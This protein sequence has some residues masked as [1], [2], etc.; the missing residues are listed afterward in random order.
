MK[1]GVDTY[2]E[3]LAVCFLAQ[4][5]F[6]TKALQAGKP[7]GK[8]EFAMEHIIK[9]GDVVKSMCFLYFLKLLK[10]A[11]RNPFHHFY[12]TQKIASRRVEQRLMR[13]H[14]P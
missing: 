12:E 11:T 3:L 14:H 10:L 1:L 9:H 8:D 4:Q 7:T 2:P 5:L 13:K 6:E